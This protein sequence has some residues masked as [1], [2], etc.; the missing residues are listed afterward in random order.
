MSPTCKFCISTLAPV[1]V[2]T[3]ALAGKQVLVAGVMHDPI[4]PAAFVLHIDVLLQQDIVV[5]P[6]FV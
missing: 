3:T 6:H 2:S 5:V 1:A 4:V